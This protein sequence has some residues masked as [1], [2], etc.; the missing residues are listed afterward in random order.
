VKNADKLIREIFK[1][2]F[3]KKTP[4]DM[5]ALARKLIA[6]GEQPDNDAP[7]RY[8]L[9]KTAQE[10]AT[11]GNDPAADDSGDRPPRQ[12]VPGQR[13]SRSSCRRSRPPRRT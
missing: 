10:V 7:T 8:A 4:A 3:A 5:V 2:D 11:Q 1:D 12:I 13:P 6:Q 9:L